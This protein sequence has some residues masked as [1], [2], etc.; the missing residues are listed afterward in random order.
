MDCIML[1]QLWSCK[2]RTVAAN[3]LLAI[4]MIDYIAS[5]YNHQIPSNLFDVRNVFCLNGT[6]KWHR[7]N[8]PKFV[9]SH[10]RKTSH[11][12]TNTP[13]FVPSRWGMTTVW[14]TQTKL[15][16]FRWIFESS[17]GSPSEGHS[18]PRGYPR[19]VASQRALKGRCAVL[20]KGSAGP[21]EVLRGSGIFRR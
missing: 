21:C 12:G 18:P 2:A 5:H 15:C 13:K 19:K 7:S 17:W 11:T 9:A 14:P 8:T 10:R 20:S 3:Q 4:F 6:S 16:E 1:S